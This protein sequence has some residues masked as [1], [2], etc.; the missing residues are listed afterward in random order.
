[1]IYMIYKAF[2]VSAFD[3]AEERRL[4]PLNLI[5]GKPFGFVKSYFYCI[6]YCILK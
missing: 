1:M 6:Y 3:N 5:I 4:T 2:L